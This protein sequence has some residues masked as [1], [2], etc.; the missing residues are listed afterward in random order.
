MSERHQTGITIYGGP[1]NCYQKCIIEVCVCYTDNWQDENP[2]LIAKFK[3]IGDA[4]FYA[5]MLSHNGPWFSQI[6]I[7]K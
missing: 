5:K 1:I 3:K 4:M 2:N 6:I 7:R